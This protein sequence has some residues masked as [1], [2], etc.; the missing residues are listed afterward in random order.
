MQGCLFRACCCPMDAAWLALSYVVL[1]RRGAGLCC[2]WLPQREA[3]ESAKRANLQCWKVA[4]LQLCF[5]FQCPVLLW[6]CTFPIY[7]PTLTFSMAYARQILKLNSLY[8]LYIPSWARAFFA[9]ASICAISSLPCSSIWGTCWLYL[10]G[11]A[12][13]HS[14][15]A[16]A[17]QTRTPQEKLQLLPQQVP[18]SLPEGTLG[19]IARQNTPA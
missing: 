10:P 14:P 8:A 13:L 4:V 11:R 9:I 19:A 6:F 3:G 16:S 12:L 5:S 1:S 18:S 2:Q 17:V 15:C 7:F